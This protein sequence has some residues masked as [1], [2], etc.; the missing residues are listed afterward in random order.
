MAYFPEAK[1]EY[2]LKIAELEGVM[3][4]RAR[5]NGQLVKEVTGLTDNDLGVFIEAF[6]RHHGE[7]FENE[8]LAKGEEHLRR[9]V[10]AFR[11]HAGARPTFAP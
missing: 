1:A 11:D 7:S 4:K 5:L 8:V 10:R 3:A 9:E 6:K 2:D